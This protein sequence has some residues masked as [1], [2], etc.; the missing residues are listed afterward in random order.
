MRYALPLYSTV[1]EKKSFA[2][3]KNYV[4]NKS[5]GSTQDILF[6]HMKC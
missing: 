1:Q 2:T 3:Y 6:S 4:F 5:D